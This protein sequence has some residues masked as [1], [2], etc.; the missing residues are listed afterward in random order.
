MSASLLG[1]CSYGKDKW[2]TALCKGHIYPHKQLRNFWKA[3][4]SLLSNMWR[5]DSCMISCSMLA[6]SLWK[7]WVIYSMCPSLWISSKVQHATV[8]YIPYTL[9]KAHIDHMKEIRTLLDLIHDD[10][11][12][13]KS[14]YRSHEAVWWIAHNDASSTAFLHVILSLSLSLSLSLVTNAVFRKK[15]SSIQSTGLWI[16]PDFWINLP[17]PPPPYNNGSLR[18]SLIPLRSVEITNILWISHIP[19]KNT[20]CCSVMKGVDLTETTCS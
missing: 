2:K 19:H 12:Y 4:F 5:F 15:K 10:L 9:Y 6:L 7:W 8:L 20:T 11:S 17:L 16:N 1:P 14:H 3:V 13:R 18:L